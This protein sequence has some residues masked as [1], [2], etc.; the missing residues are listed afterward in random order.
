MS[1]KTWRRTSDNSVV[2]CCEN[3]YSGF[4]PG[5]DMATYVV[6]VEKDIPIMPPPLPTASATKKAAL[7]A[8]PTVPQSVKDYLA[9][10]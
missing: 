2:G 10:I 3:G 1:Y 5:G 6:S 8:D 9:T 4:E 7:L